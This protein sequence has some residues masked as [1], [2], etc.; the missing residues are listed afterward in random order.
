MLV[1]DFFGSSLVILLLSLPLAA[2][3]IH[4]GDYVALGNESALLNGALI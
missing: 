3:E 2:F 4:K 1:L